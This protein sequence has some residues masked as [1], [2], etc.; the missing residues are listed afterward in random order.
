MN[1]D[2]PDCDWTSAHGAQAHIATPAFDVSPRTKQN[3]TSTRRQPQPQSCPLRG[4]TR[5][6]PSSVSSATG[7][8]P[9]GV[10][11]IE[12]ADMLTSI[13][14]PCV[15]SSTLDPRSEVDND[16][17]ELELDSD[18]ALIAGIKERQ[19]QRRTS[20]GPKSKVPH[21]GIPTFF[22]SPIVYSKTLPQR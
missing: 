17:N 1:L 6:G 10:H 12:D 7:S 8:A 5:L 2:E 9:D 16:N 11:L 4:E 15:Q 13:G 18:Q 20:A 3:H 14:T 22:L 21:S 19:Q